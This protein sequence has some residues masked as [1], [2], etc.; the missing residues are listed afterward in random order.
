[1]WWSTCSHFNYVMKVQVGFGESMEIHQIER[2]WERHE[3]QH[4]T[5][6][7]YVPDKSGTATLLSC[8]PRNNKTSDEWWAVKNTH[9]INKFKGYAGK[10]W[11]LGFIWILSRTSTQ[12]WRHWHSLTATVSPTIRPTLHNNLIRCSISNITKSLI[13]WHPKITSIKSSLI[14]QGQKDQSIYSY[15]STAAW[16]GVWK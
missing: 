6:I 16:A 11:V 8:S 4:G 14:M 15:A 2:D 9:H 5:S 7:P 13:H 10:P 12:P 3:N 1:M